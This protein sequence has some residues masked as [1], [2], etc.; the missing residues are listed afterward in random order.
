MQKSTQLLLL[1]ALGLL[2]SRPAGAQNPRPLPSPAAIASAPWWAQQMYSGTGNIY[3]ID[4]A[5]AAWRRKHPAEQTLHSRYYKHWRRGVGSHISPQG[6]YSPPDPATE[7][8][9]FKNW[10]QH[11]EAAPRNSNWENLGPFVTYAEGENKA[12]SWQLNLYCLEQ[13][14]DNPD[15]LFAGSE[16]GLV[17]KSTNGGQNW[18][19]TASGINTSGGIGAVGVHPANPD[20]AW[21][22]DSHNV[23]KSTDGGNSWQLMLTSNNLHCHAIYLH[24]D[25]PNLVLLATEKGLYRSVNGGSD[26][27]VLFNQKCWD[28]EAKTDD[29]NTLFLLRN[30]PAT[31]LCEFLKSTDQGQNWTLLTNGWINPAL[32]STFDNNDGGARLAVT[33]ADPNRIY[34]VLLGQYN[35]GVNDNNYLGVYRSNDAGESWNLP[36]ANANGGPGGPYA[37]SHTCLVTFWFNNDQRYPNATYEYDQGFYNLAID[38]SDTDPDKFLVGFLNLFKSEDGGL[39]FQRWG[40]YGGG[41]GWQHPDIQDIEIN[42]QDVWVCSDGGLNKYAPD[43]SSH[44][45]RSDGMAGSDFWGFDGG[46]N[47]DIVTGGRYHNG[48]TAAIIGTY[49]TGAYIRL[50]GAEATT[51]YVHPAGGR[52]VMHSDI[53]P[54]ILPT[55]VTGPVSGFSFSAYPNEGYA[56]NN[57]NSSELEPDPRCYNHLFMGFENTIQKSEDG[58]LSW[59]TLAS[60]G[61][62]PARFVTGIEVSRSNPDVIY[63]LHNDGTTKLRKSTDGGQTWTLAGLPPSPAN[64]AFIS[65]DPLDENHLWLAWNRGGSSNL[66]VFETADGGATWTNLTTSILAGHFVEQLL[67]IG[68]TDGGVYLA[69]HLGIFYRSQSEAD[70]VPCSEGL[71]AR[72]AVNRMVPFYAKGK[73]RIAT[74]GSGIWQSDFYEAP[75][76]T[77]VQP[78][79]DKLVANC[80]RDTFYFDDYSMVN[81]DG[82]SWQWSFEPAPQYTSALNVRNPRV[83]FGAAGSYTATMTLNGIYTRS[84]TLTVNAAC[85]A[86]TI[87]GMALSLDGGG[88]AAALGNLNL[89]S[90]AMTFTCWVKGGASQNP[91]APFLFARGGG[92]TFG[93]GLGDDLGLRYHWNDEHWWWDSG[94]SLP[95]DTWSHVALVITPGGATIYLNGVGSSNSVPHSP[96]EFNTPLV[97]GW[98]PTNNERRFQGLI[99]EVTVWKKALSQA[100]IR[101]LMHLTKVPAAHPDLVSY[102]QFNELSGQA[103]DRIGIRHL[104][105]AGTAGR[106]TSTAPLG[107]GLSA[108]LTISDS[109]SYEFGSTGLTLQFGNGSIL[110]DGE[111]VASRINLSPDQLP[112]PFPYGKA[113]WVINNYGQNFFFDFPQLLRFDNYGDIPAG[114]GAADFKLYGRGAFDDGDTW[115]S[116]LDQAS[117]VTN[118]AAGSVSFSSG[119]GLETAAQLLVLRENVNATGEQDFRATLQADQSVRLQWTAGTK[120]L[121]G[122]LLERGTGEGEFEFFKK[123]NISAPGQAAWQETD[124]QPLRGLNVYR[125]SHLD[126]SGRVLH[127]ALASVVV[128]ALPEPWVLFPNPLAAGQALRVQTALPGAYRLIVYDPQG[129]VKLARELQGEAILNDCGLAPGVYGFQ[130]LREGYRQFGKLVVVE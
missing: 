53:N 125:L 94:L 80:A 128:N 90:N 34:A 20:I 23:H 43:F 130:L 7:Q 102:Y 21:F 48:N 89:N 82:A 121:G 114:A 85:D 104:S 18:T 31:R 3:Q 107:G 14:K 88:H 100:E 72:A 16:N 51:G 5:F 50:G 33:Q 36:N 49:P 97:I 30:N 110:P 112:E 60:F 95:A 22:A 115:G 57:E 54:K 120:E 109:G 9:Y 63:C 126:K 77:L 68:G 81:H 38:A 24:P 8:Q 116:A 46:W 28:L 29:P 84:L 61:S 96:E 64:G 103:L 123:I 62:D 55:T 19:P 1:L 58:G 129:R 86:D 101:E 70:W 6:Q 91:W 13:C 17:F 73:V 11:R 37:G 42:G 25:N 93:I 79:V 119:N 106:S 83:V 124:L 76:A 113:Y 2:T 87:P 99:D 59:T 12:V 26:W 78:T 45:A 127:S 35:D 4:S 47:E 44:E 108:R 15:V 69:T 65:L 27:T 67:H 41:P 10:M 122:F 111:V 74:Y 52:K 39:T 118:G 105:V 66:K 71:P 40:G 56:G 98:D 32:N 117:T 75:A 92:T